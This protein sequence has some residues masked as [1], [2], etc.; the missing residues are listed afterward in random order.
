MNSSSIDY[1]SSNSVVVGAL[2]WVITFSLKKKHA[3][4]NFWIPSI[5]TLKP[6][7][8]GKTTDF[9]L[10]NLFNAILVTLQDVL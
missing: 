4:N 9:E 3:V 8:I 7:K 6:I 1:T 2:V 10:R 5:H